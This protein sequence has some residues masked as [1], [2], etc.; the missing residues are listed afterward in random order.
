MLEQV[1][2]DNNNLQGGINEVLLGVNP[3][4]VND[5]ELKSYNMSESISK[6]KSIGGADYNDQFKIQ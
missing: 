3:H 2:I 6:N 4:N 1:M 5:L